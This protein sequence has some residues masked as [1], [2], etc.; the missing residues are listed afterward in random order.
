MKLDKDTA[1]KILAADFTN[2]MKKVKSGK[3]LTPAERTLVEKH[4]AESEPTAP[5]KEKSSGHIRDVITD[6]AVQDAQREERA[7]SSPAIDAK[8]P[9]FLREDTVMNMDAAVS[10]TKLSREIVEAAR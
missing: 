9:K 2:V 3:P 7:K 4:A 6:M 10:R 8:A 5:P 1:A